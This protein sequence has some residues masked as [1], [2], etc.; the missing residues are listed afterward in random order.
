M[1]LGIEQ[2]AESSPS[3]GILL[4]VFVKCA[5]E[6]VDALSAIGDNGDDE[7][8]GLCEWTLSSSIE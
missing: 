6:L 5:A 8:I 1:A 4:F 2:R 3:R 7:P